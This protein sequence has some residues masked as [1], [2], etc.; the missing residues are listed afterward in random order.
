LL[1]QQTRRSDA[2]SQA[3]AVHA[4]NSASKINADIALAG[5]RGLKH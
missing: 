5:R 3:S 1:D 4:L 2:E